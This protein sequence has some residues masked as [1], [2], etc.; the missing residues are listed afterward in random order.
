[1][2]PRAT[3]SYDHA[4][5]SKSRS[6]QAESWR[7][8]NWELYL[9][10]IWILSGKSVCVTRI[11]WIFYVKK[12]KSKRMYA[13][14]SVSIANWNVILIGLP[15]HKYIEINICS[16]MNLCKFKKNI[17]VILTVS[18]N[19]RSC[20]MSCCKRKHTDEMNIHWKRFLL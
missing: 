17:Q 20:L 16:Q 19:S 8:V 2:Q 12:S 15:N 7:K 6:G 9:V 10:Q 18:T 4:L 14:S 1:M 13:C 11:G 5:D 3:I